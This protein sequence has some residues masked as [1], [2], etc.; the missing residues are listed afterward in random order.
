MTR[1]L[2]GWLAAFVVETGI[3]GVA[4][5]V[6]GPEEFDRAASFKRLYRK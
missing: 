6:L 1:H 3:V 5:K 4:Q 2:A